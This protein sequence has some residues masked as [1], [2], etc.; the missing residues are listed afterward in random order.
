MF[1][2][3]LCW[4]SIDCKSLSVTLICSPLTLFIRLDPMYFRGLDG[5]L[6]IIVSAISIFLWLV[7][8]QHSTIVYL[9]QCCCS[10]AWCCYV[11]AKQVLNMS[12]KQ[13]PSLLL[14]LWGSPVSEESETQVRTLPGSVHVRPRRRL[15]TRLACNTQSEISGETTGS[16]YYQ[17]IFSSQL[18]I[19]I[20]TE[21]SSPNYHNKY[22]IAFNGHSTLRS[23]IEHDRNICY[24]S[25]LSCKG[26][27]L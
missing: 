17:R 9:F 18:K 8:H 1:V 23:S 5:L 12:I 3:Y 2:R 24:Q 7:H 22:T 11:W 21:H 27:K 14:Q 26:N 10:K 25:F 19:R 4:Y 13:Q 20:W 15:H 16:G 6:H